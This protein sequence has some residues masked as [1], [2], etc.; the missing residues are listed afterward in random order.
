[1]ARYRQDSN[2]NFA[3]RMTRTKSSTAAVNNAQDR[4]LVHA[5]LLK[6]LA[7]NMLPPYTSYDSRRFSRRLVLVQAQEPNHLLPQL[8]MHRIEFWFMT[9]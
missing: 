4:V 8:T 9:C 6:G 7:I 5:T 3:T 2:A 1:M